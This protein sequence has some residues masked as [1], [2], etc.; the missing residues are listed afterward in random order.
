LIGAFEERG[1][2]KFTSKE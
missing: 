2:D 1:E